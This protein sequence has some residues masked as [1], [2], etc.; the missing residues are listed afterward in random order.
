[1][2]I[3][4]NHVNIQVDEVTVPYYAVHKDGIIAGFFG[5]FRWLSNFYPLENGVCLDEI[6]YPSVEN[7]F[8]AC[9]WPHD[10]REQFTTCSPGQAKRLGKLA[11]NFDQKKWTKKKYELMFELNWQKYHNNP[12]LRSKLI[13]TE[14]FHL[15]ERNNW[16]DRFWGT[17]VNGIGENNLGIILMTIRD[18][19]IGNQNKN[20]F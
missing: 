17:D 9:K 5:I 15:E 6:Y 13:L 16:S 8:Q 1:M 4:S 14:G 20:L 7:V 3:M 19:I 12:I 2:M 18:I 11:P 10:Q